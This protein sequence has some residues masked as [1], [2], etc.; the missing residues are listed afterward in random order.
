MSLPLVS[1]AQHHVG[2]AN[3]ADREVLI[4]NPAVF[5]LK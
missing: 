4:N 3:L 1:L 5:D 2:N